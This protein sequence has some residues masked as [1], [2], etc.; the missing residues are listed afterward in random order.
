MNLQGININLVR[1]EYEYNKY[2]AEDDRSKYDY[3]ASK[4]SLPWLIIDFSRTLEEY[5]AD[6]NKVTV[7]FSADA[8]F[9]NLGSDYEKNGF[10]VKS[11]DTGKFEFDAQRFG[12]LMLE[13]KKDCGLDAVPANMEVKATDALGNVFKTKLDILDLTDKM[14]LLQ[15]IDENIIQQGDIFLG[16]LLYEIIAKQN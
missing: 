2:V 5:G 10:A 1:N 6:R 14:A 9:T 13:A 11:G 15:G 7:E 8:N 4:A 3:E 16:K 12:R